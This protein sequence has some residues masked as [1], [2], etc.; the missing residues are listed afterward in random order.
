MERTTGATLPELVVEV[1][2]LLLSCCGTVLANFVVIVVVATKEKLHAPTYFYY[3]S[4]A[5]SDFILGV[6]CIPLVMAAFILHRWP[7]GNTLCQLYA[8]LISMSVN[9]S[10]VTLAI[11]SVDRYFALSKPVESKAHLT[12]TK[13]RYKLIIVA[14][15]VHSVFWASGPLF[16]WGSTKLD[17]FTHTCKPDWGGEGLA[18]KTYALCLAFF[19][20]AVPVSAMIY[21]YY[22]IYRIARASRS[23]AA[24]YNPQ[25]ENLPKGEHVPLKESTSAIHSNAAAAAEDNKALKTVLLLIGS[26]AACWS[27]YTLAT[28]WKILAPNSVPPWIVRIGLVLTLCS[29]CIDPFIYSIRD[30]KMRRE[31]KEIICKILCR[32]H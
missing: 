10:V 29:C 24:R 23:V 6:F 7:I 8:V 31:I 11:I 20:F 9:C 18:N 30:E 15:W 5:V 2:L 28:V 1:I 25:K 26:F 27:I 19:A 21:A 13:R 17:E 12:L 3:L 16:K 32:N 4:L 22:K 14:S